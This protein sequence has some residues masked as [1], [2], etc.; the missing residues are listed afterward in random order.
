MGSG[1][2]KLIR[3][4]YPE[5]YVADSKA[6]LL[7]T[8]ILGNISIA[9]T[10]DK[11]IIN[12][13]GQFLYGR[14][15][16]KTNYEAVYQGLEK[17]RHYLETKKITKVGFPYKMGCVLGGG[18]WKIVNAMIESVF[19]DFSGDVYIVKLDVP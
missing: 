8:N 17:V 10:K 14:E 16:R 1:I 2:A 6:A 3:A 12:I 15:S 9:N 7:G 18:D 4:K 19:S 11:T 13:Y 5:A